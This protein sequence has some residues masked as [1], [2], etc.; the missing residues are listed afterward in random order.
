ME[1]N[2]STAILLLQPSIIATVIRTTMSIMSKKTTTTM[3]SSINPSSRKEIYPVY[4]CMGKVWRKFFGSTPLLMGKYI[5][6]KK[7]IVQKQ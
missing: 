5:F 2:F 3:D 7:I 4:H 1:D 6:D